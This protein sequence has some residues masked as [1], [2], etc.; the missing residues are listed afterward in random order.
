VLF[1]MFDAVHHNNFPHPT[2]YGTLVFK[3]VNPFINLNK[4]IVQ[5]VLGSAS[6]FTISDGHTK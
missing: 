5:Y 3:S 6:V 2:L 4:T 1:K